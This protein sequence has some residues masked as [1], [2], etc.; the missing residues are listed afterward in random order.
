MIE[1]VVVCGD[2]FATGVGIPTERCYEDFFG[3]LVAEE[4]NLPLR[5]FARSGCCNFA[6]YLQVKKVIEQYQYSKIK[7]L[8]L[9]SV[10]YHERYMIP[11]VDNIKNDDLDLKHIQYKEYEPYSDFSKPQRKIEFELADEPKFVSQTITNINLY[12]EGEQAGAT[13]KSLD[14]VPRSKYNSLMNYIADVDNEK[15]KYEYDNAII[16]KAH[17]L[18]LNNNIPHIIMSTHDDFFKHLNQK[19]VAIVDW[20]GLCK[21]FP[22]NLGTGHCDENGHKEVFEILKPKVEELLK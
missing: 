20:G 15:I 9:V 8:V 12:L 5:V 6:I 18:L 19:N 4:L 3:G 14:V 16:T 2:S 11:I 7:P 13:T 17:L 22:D 21:R 1:S 10:T